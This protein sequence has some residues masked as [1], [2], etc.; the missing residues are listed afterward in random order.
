MAS[1]QAGH[2]HRGVMAVLPLLVLWAGR[3][4]ASDRSVPNQPVPP[5]GQPPS[6]EDDEDPDEP[7]EPDGK[8]EKVRNPK[9]GLMLEVGI[10]GGGDDVA[11]VYLS[12]GTHQ[13]LSAG[14]GAAIS[15]GIMVTPLWVGDRLGVGVSGTVG[16]KAW[17]VGA[18]NGDIG[19]SRYPLIAAV[20]L[21]PR[22]APR[23]LLLLRGGI[24]KEANVSI[25]GTG[26]AAGIG[27]D[28]HATTGGFGEGGFYKIMD[29]PEQRG[30][31]SLTFRYTTL[32]YTANGGAADAQSLMV[33]WALYFNP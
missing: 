12:N 31:W 4:E 14:D 19:L 15:L 28:L 24:D 2:F 33:F 32:T 26:V 3:I 8:P 1:R 18:S 22:L 10:G 11:K 9:W 25:S 30:A 17:S 29:T 27:A 13:T 16:Y 6:S 20:H 5:I 7:D 23:W 21:L